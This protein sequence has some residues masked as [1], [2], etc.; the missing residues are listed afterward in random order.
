MN[1]V[2]QL[3]MSIEEAQRYRDRV[4]EV[5]EYMKKKHAA[6]MKRLSKEKLS[7]QDRVKLEDARRDLEKV[8]L[9]VNVTNLIRVIL[10]HGSKTV[11]AFTDEFLLDQIEKHA[12]RRGRPTK[13]AEGFEKVEVQ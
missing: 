10:D 1:A 7:A 8:M 11:L 9:D 12:A 4:A 2:M 13:L 3:K 5:K 6:V